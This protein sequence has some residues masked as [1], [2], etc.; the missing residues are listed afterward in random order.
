MLGRA[1]V[2]DGQVDSRGNRP[3]L[4]WVV[5]TVSLLWN[6]LGTILWSG[7]SFM[8]DTFLDGQPI[9]YQEYVS[10]LPVW[11]VVSWGLGVV[12]GLAGSVLLLVRQKTAI[13]VFGLSL[14]GAA[15][16]QAAYI[17]NPPPADFVNLPLVV[18]IIGFAAFMLVFAWLMERRAIIR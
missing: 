18:F 9:A 10:T 13:S 16:N 2:T 17:T 15:V 12:A 5:G 6:G 3:W 8:P 14:F 1:R 4:L 11:T 7:T